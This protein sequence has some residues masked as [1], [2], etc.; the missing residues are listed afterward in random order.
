MIKLF[1]LM[2][3]ALGGWKGQGVPPSKGN[4]F[5]LECNDSYLDEQALTPGGVVG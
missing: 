4:L 2:R 3:K 1:A 5:A